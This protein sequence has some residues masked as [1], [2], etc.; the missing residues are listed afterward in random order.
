MAT[1]TPQWSGFSTWK[2]SI[3]P[4]GDHDY[5]QFVLAAPGKVT[6]VTHD[7]GGVTQK[8][9]DLAVAMDGYAALMS[10]G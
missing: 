1:A 8:D 10:G 3:S 9:I 6:L 7:A 5:Y 4:V 2:G